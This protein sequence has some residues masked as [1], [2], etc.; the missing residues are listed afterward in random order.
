[1]HG[2][3]DSGIA[4]FRPFVH[5]QSSADS[6]CA[7][8]RKEEIT[9]TIIV[10]NDMFS[11]PLKCIPHRFRKSAFLTLIRKNIPDGSCSS[12]V[13]HFCGSGQ[14]LTEIALCYDAVFQQILNSRNGQRK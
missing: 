7:F 10:K 5:D 8:R 14:R 6:E 12:P 13:I 11:G 1:M 4:F 9:S 3:V 2:I